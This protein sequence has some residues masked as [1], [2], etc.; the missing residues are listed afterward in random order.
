M[1][2]VSSSTITPSFQVRPVEVSSSDTRSWDMRVQMTFF[3]KISSILR[4]ISLKVRG[5]GCYKI[6]EKHHQKRGIDATE[7]RVQKGEDQKSVNCCACLDPF[8]GEDRSVDMH[9]QLDISPHLFH[10]KCIIQYWTTL[11]N[12]RKFPR[13][14]CPLC[15]QGCGD[16]ADR[17]REFE[18][19]FIERAYQVRLAYDPDYPYEVPLFVA[20]QHGEDKF[21]RRMIEEGR[22]GN[23]GG[24]PTRREIDSALDQAIHR[25]QIGVILELLSLGV[26]DNEK[27]SFLLARAVAESAEL[28]SIFLER[29]DPD[30]NQMV[31][32]FLQVQ[33][34]WRLACRVQKTGILLALAIGD[35]KKKEAL[36]PIYWGE[37]WLAL[38]EESRF[39]ALLKQPLADQYIDSRALVALLFFMIQQSQQSKYGVRTLSL[40]GSVMRYVMSRDRGPWKDILRGKI[41]ENI[42][43]ALSYRVANIKKANLPNEEERVLVETCRLIALSLLADSLQRKESDWQQ[44]ID[45]RDGKIGVVSNHS[46]SEWWWSTHAYLVHVWVDYE[47]ILILLGNLSRPGGIR[48]LSNPTDQ[49]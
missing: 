27:K 20:V 19:R 18:T 28:F 8:D 46:Q 15:R 26:S 38:S 12:A 3:S 47:S 39:I 14:I 24:A 22:G 40:V 23:G 34:D 42:L 33:R 45:I 7:Q 13:Q 31:S 11:D 16:I 25:D 4:G 2:I 29:L 32:T 1:Q 5:L 41:K 48:Q 35:V 21:L 6:R 30:P 36:A 43:L 44:A 17:G 37:F 10:Q 9:P 49:R